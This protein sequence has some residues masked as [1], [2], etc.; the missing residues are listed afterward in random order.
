MRVLVI[1]PL[2]PPSPNSEAICG[3]KFVL[4]LME[5]GIKT[6]VIFSSNVQTV[7]MFDESRMWEPLRDIAIDVPNQ[8]VSILKRCSLGIRYQSTS[9]VSWTHLVVSKA[10]ELHSR[11]RFDVVVSRSLP[12]HAHIA[13][14]WV[15]CTLKLPWVAVDNDPWD[16]SGFAPTKTLSPDWRMTPNFRFWRRRIL[17]G[18]DRLCFPCDRLRDFCFK[19]LRRTAGSLIVP[20]IG[21]A[22]T[23][24]RR[25]DFLIVHTGKLG[26]NE[27]T[28][29]SPA[30]LLEAMKQLFLFR[31][32]AKL[33]TRLLLVGPEDAKTVEYARSLGLS[34]HV[35]S[36]GV[37][38]YEE[39]LGYIAQAAV[40][41]LIEANLKEGVF[42]PSKL[43]DY[44]VARKPVLALSPELGTVADLAAEQGI[45]RVSPN[46]PNAVAAALTQMFDAFLESRIDAYAPSDW[47]VQQ[48]SG[49]A[50]IE[51]FLTSIAPLSLSQR[52]VSAAVGEKE[53]QE[54]A[55]VAVG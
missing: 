3:G 42:L 20:H 34:E 6:S 39:S 48:F 51:D 18:A 54:K 38:N 21:R 53:E 49:K 16:F 9:W 5:S 35:T 4:A 50:V 13:G 28:A 40:C 19:G 45:M 25:A 10:R 2:F 7:S 17:A 47:L 12:R 1:S 24:E 14:Y 22:V 46:D 32:A 52:H 33:R 8:P 23:S 30:P 43:C 44:I 26:S 15:A 36:T 41:L 29:R 55:N 37:V 27:I 31:P 11:N